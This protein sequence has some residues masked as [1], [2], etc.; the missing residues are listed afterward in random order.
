MADRTVKVTLTAHVAQYIAG[1]EK[2]AQSTRETGTEAEKLAQKK[3]AFDLL[4][5]S[6]LAIGTVAGVAVGIAVAKFAEF[7]QAMSNVQAATQESASNMDLLRDAALDAGA[8]TVFTA[9]EAANAIEELGKNGLTTQQILSGGLKGALSL[10]SAGQLDVARAAEIASVSM[11]QFGLAG[12]DIPHVADLL[13]AGAGKA[14]GDVDD[15]AQALAQAALVAHQTGLSIEDTTG[16]L[17]AFADQGL[18]GSDAGTSLKTMLQRLTPQSKEA[19]DEIKRLNVEAYDANG[20]FVGITTVAGKYKDALSKLTPEQRNASLQIIF[21]SDAVRAASVLY[22]EGAD[23]IQKYIDQTNDSGYAAKVAAD[24]LNNLAGDV[25]KLGGSFDTAL[26]KSGS[27]ANDVLRLLVQSATGVVDA[28]GALP[29]PVLGAGL[30]LGGVAA[31]T[32]IVGGAALLAVPKMAQFKI[33]LETLKISGGSAAKGIGLASG[34]LAVAGIAF[35]IWAAR[36]AEATSTA[37]EFKDS[38]DASTGAVTAYTRELVAKKLAESGAF[39]A[40]KEAGVS[41]KQLTT[42]VIEGGDALDKVKKKI[43]DNN[44]FL[45]FFSGVGIRA[46]NASQSINDLASGLE[47][48]EKNFKD[49]AAAAEGSAASTS[50]ASD[51]YVD[52]AKTA[53]DLESNLR[54]LIDTVNKANGVGQDAI[55]ANINYQDALAKV[56]EQIQKAREG[57]EGYALTLDQSSQA[58]RDNLSMLNDLA[59]DSQNA[60]LAQYTLDGNTA[61]YKST[62]EAGRQA[63]IDRAM[64]LGATA[65]EAT[66]LAN[67]IYAIPTEHQFTLIAETAEA[68]ARIQ[69]IQDAVSN[70]KD[71]TVHINVTMPN[72]APVT[73]KQLA[74]QFG[75]GSANGRVVDYFADGGMT[76]NHVAQIAPAGS[77]RV[78]AEPETG[79][80]AY[81]PLAP[82]KRVRALQVWRETGRRLGAE[83]YANGGTRQGSLQYAQGP[84]VHVATP[85]SYRG[86]DTNIEVHSTHQDPS[87]LAREIFREA[88]WEL[89]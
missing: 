3:D 84:T 41:Q 56:D 52:A 16:V 12:G 62:L 33:A 72:G 65:E 71:K 85:A 54:Q 59:A 48:G 44:T 19:A 60:A 61:N 45:T 25:E 40:A 22:S 5:R 70:L 58:G 87:R 28:I 29:E 80:E 53:S 14:A 67:Q 77:W 10:A 1:M 46:G 43:G 36:Q 37:S 88:K 63:V 27:A 50:S 83:T 57:Q 13:A 24:R 79:G 15:L 75:F 31:A 26:I 81:I 89:S 64:A 21:G 35:S 7:D 47:R 17:A 74:D 4:G 69:R 86:G 51:T 20:Q 9:T 11:K 39:D 78:W 66:N 49:Q 2:A 34:A 73:D 68:A 55:S 82:S 23:G 8:S 6:M 30:A 18:I 42:A 38:L 32:G 76:E